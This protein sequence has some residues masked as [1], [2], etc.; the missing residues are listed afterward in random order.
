MIIIIIIRRTTPPQD[1]HR[2]GSLEDEDALIRHCVETEQH[3]VQQQVF[4]GGG[5]E[6]GGNKNA[7]FSLRLFCREREYVEW[8]LSAWFF[9]FL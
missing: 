3:V 1:R 5:R 9:F 2:F 8:L 6:G 4:F 7:A